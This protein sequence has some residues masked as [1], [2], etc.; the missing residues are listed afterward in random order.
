MMQCSLVG[1]PVLPPLLLL[2]VVQRDVALLV[3][4][5]GGRGRRKEVLSLLLRL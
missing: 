5:E 3:G 2:L 4:E 1:V